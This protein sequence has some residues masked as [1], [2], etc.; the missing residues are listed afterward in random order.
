M[1]RIQ[2]FFVGEW[3]VQADLD[4]ISR[5]GKEVTLQPQ[6]MD[7]LVFM[8][9]HKD[10]VVTAETLME[11]LWP[12][13]LVTSSSIYV[14]MKHLR[15]ALGDD[16]HRSRYIKTIP[17]RG[18]QM[19]AEVSGLQGRFKPE[20]ANKRRFFSTAV[21]ASG[22]IIAAA[23]LIVAFGLRGK[24]GSDTITQSLPDRPY[25]LAVLPFEGGDQSFAVNLQDH[26]TTRFAAVNSMQVIERGSV[27]TASQSGS[28]LAEIGR[29]L[30]A[31]VMISGQ[32]QQ[33][34]KQLR[35][36]VQLI[37]VSSNS[38]LWG[39]TFDRII[40]PMERFAV[41]SEISS[42]IIAAVRKELEIETGLDASKLPSPSLE[43]YEQYLLGKRKLESR[44]LAGMR[45][46]AHHLA[47][48]VELDPAFALAWAT[49]AKAHQLLRS[50]GEQ[51]SEMLRTM[52]KTEIDRALELNPELGEAHIV[53]GHWIWT[54]GDGD[55][56]RAEQEFQMGLRQNPSDAGAYHWYGNFLAFQGRREEALE[57]FRLGLLRD[58]LSSVIRLGLAVNLER[59]NRPQDA[60]LEFQRAMAINP[61]FPGLKGFLARSEVSLNGN[62]VAALPLLFDAM[63]QNESSAVSLGI[64]FLQLEDLDSAA[65][66]LQWAETRVPEVGF[67]EYLRA[68]FNWIKSGRSAPG[69]TFEAL[70]RYLPAE[71]WFREGRRQ[72][73]RILHLQR[74]Y[75]LAHGR[76]EA[77]LR[78]YEQQFPSLVNAA[79]TH[80]DVDTYMAAIDL[81]LV[82]QQIGEFERAN[83]LAQ[84]A[85]SVTDGLERLGA[86]GYRLADVQALAVIGDTPQALERLEGA[87]KEGYREAALYYLKHDPN[88]AT[89]HAEPKF[90]D[91]LGKVES[92]L[93]N[94]RREIARLQSTGEL[95]TL[96][97]L[98]E[99]IDQDS[100]RQSPD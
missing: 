73:A 72:V 68:K 98:M 78:R 44:N 25:T 85:L 94:Q 7:L 27:E 12:G 31:D 88:L 100:A 10:D 34:D 70:S 83:A 20:S 23:S 51:D 21:T 48:A 5:N 62:F 86:H 80:V 54:G 97:T 52:A 32:L 93:S 90:K 4:L 84:L 60:Y 24:P 81:A 14:T 56:S 6:V 66:I 46:A 71:P 59:V 58:P 61:D 2:P 87:L 82:Y 64:Y 69:D 96:D 3:L 95:M 35:I 74:N 41:Q 33:N 89:L 49:L 40:M 9:R 36:Q 11:N 17:K 67:I 65:K 99:S 1:S 26:L 28:A 29:K 77:A 45:T 15:D 19:I 30:G 38:L 42:I 39:T 47:K 75:D 55:L 37:E 76:P 22:I 53:L 79:L 18:Y 8:A 16:P 57:Q 50:Y 63:A 91:L 13:K 92:D 43:A